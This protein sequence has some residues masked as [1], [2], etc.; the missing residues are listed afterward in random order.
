MPTGNALVL[1]S[2]LFASGLAGC[3]GNDEHSDRLAQP[4][5][6][7]ISVPTRPPPRQPTIAYNFSDPGYRVD[8]LWRVGDGWDY[9]SNQ[10]HV[11]RLRVVDSRLANGTT[12]YLI[13]EKVGQV[14]MPPSRTTIAWVDGRQW[15]LL[16]VTDVDGGEDRYRPGIP[17]RYYRNGSFAFEHTRTEGSGRVSGN[18]SL[19]VQSRLFS[20]HQTILFPWG[21]VEAKRVEQTAFVRGGDREG[22]TTLH[23]IHRDYANDVQYQLPGGET[24][25]ITAAKVGEFRRGTLGS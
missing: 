2:L 22:A 23:W 24:F 17:L 3:F 9:Q 12:Y 5:D 6:E 1:A 19:T 14:D 25:K 10:S 18:A 11:R 20:T 4:T 13:E 16:N 7:P 15:L 21:Y 8:A